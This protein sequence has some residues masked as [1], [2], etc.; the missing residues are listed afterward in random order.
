MR[1]LRTDVKQNPLDPTS[2]GD[3][4]SVAF[5]SLSD[6]KPPSSQ[7]ATREKNGLENVRPLD[8][9]PLDPHSPSSPG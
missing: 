8:F 4:L 9:D 5:V 3:P 6:P 1:L 2:K 7:T